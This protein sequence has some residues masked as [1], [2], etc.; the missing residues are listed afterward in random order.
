MTTPI[1][2]DS[3]LVGLVQQS[4]DV[5]IFRGVGDGRLYCYDDG[6]WTPD[7]D[8]EIQARMDM[9][10]G[11]TKWPAAKLRN[12]RYLFRG[13]EPLMPETPPNEA[14]LLVNVLNGVVDVA[15]HPEPKLRP[16][17]P[18]FF[19]RYKIPHEY[20]ASATCPRIDA[21]LSDMFPDDD[22]RDLLFEI[23]G[24]CLLPGFNLKK[25]ILFYSREP[26]TGKTTLLN[27]LG[28][29]VGHE[30]EATVSLQD[31]DDHRFARASL[32]GKLINRSGDLGAYA[33]RSSSNFKSLVGGDP[34]LAEHKGQRQFALYN[35]A[36]LLFAGN[37]FA[38]THEQGAAYATRWLVVPF[39]K[40]FKPNPNFLEEVSSKSEMEGLLAHAIRGAARLVERNEFT[41]T[42]STLRAEDQLKMDTDSVARYV[43][44]SLT[45]D[46]NAEPLDG[47]STYRDYDAWARDGG[48]RPV[49]KPN[50]Y[51][52][53]SDMPGISVSESRSRKKLLHGLRLVAP[54][55]ATIV[56][57]WRRNAQ[58]I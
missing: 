55:E 5:P 22:M 41:S 32:Q 47:T 37:S 20:R 58:D 36:K 23:L 2:E 29:L 14:K 7:G 51:A 43:S 4:G 10:M 6:V 50:F 46:P 45:N 38:G 9:A 30:N 35:T 28:L 44:E 18:A 40:Q 31:L 19:F 42:A 25:A 15:A 53:L 49:G 3:E 54:T 57:K 34:V 17:D 11:S 8:D 1:P 26:H 13:V 56:D 16:N 33:P 21:A 27:L 48:L 24:Y 12:V 39:T 52:R